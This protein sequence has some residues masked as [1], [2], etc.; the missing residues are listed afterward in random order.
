MN[1]EKQIQIPEPLFL[2][3]FKYFIA[4]KADEFNYIADEINRK[5]DKM[6]EHDLYTKSKMAATPEEREKARQEYLDRKGIPQSV[7][8]S[9]GWSGVYGENN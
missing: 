1:R 7:R 9:E 5:L 8:W 2:A 4:G 3:I 6:I